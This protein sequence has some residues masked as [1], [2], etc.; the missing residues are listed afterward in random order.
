MRAGLKVK[1]AR[2]SAELTQTK[3]ANA[4]GCSRSLIKLIEGGLVPSLHIAMQIA[5]ALNVPVLDLWPD[6]ADDASKGGRA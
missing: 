3:L 4:A 5:E 2:L 6:I 1:I